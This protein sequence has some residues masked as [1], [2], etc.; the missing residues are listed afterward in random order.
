MEKFSLD[1]ENITSNGENYIKPL[2]INENLYKDQYP[3]EFEK[4]Q[5]NEKIEK[6]KKEI[7][8][9]Y[10]DTNNTEDPTKSSV[11]PQG[12][13]LKEDSG[14]RL[15]DNTTGENFYP[16]SA[17]V[18][19]YSDPK[20]EYFISL[21]TKGILNTSDFFEKDGKYYSK[22]MNVENTKSAK[23][24]EVD[25]E[26]FLLKYLFSD[27]DHDMQY[28]RE[29]LKKNVMKKNVIENKNGQFVHFDY[30]RGLDSGNFDEQFGF[31]EKN[32]EELINN[33]HSEINEK[34][35]QLHLNILDH[36]VI[37]F[38]KG[39]TKRNLVNRIEDKILP[40]EE[41]F[42]DVGFFN[43]VINKSGLDLNI[44]RFNF[45]DGTTREEKI[46]SLRSY[47]IER[48]EILKETLK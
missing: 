33:I 11:L 25:A 43:A 42:K 9:I 39:K 22:E 45:L 44:E 27:S 6:I 13:D 4:S 18:S 38:F 10:K 23:K 46:D 28:D 12:L 37:N 32:K 24:M 34:M 5:T 29:N 26:I 8:L 40:L 3:N 41:H 17:E 48:L 31:T 15:Q 21:V 1:S 19:H 14:N 47:F 35:E 20:T 7:K 36:K 16:K 30:G 2:K